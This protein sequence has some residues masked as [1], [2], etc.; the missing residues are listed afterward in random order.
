MLALPGDYHCGTFKP[1]GDVMHGHPWQ[2][3]LNNICRISFGDICTWL[4][5]LMM[6]TIT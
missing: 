5:W 6:P 3:N 4:P 2:V 1:D